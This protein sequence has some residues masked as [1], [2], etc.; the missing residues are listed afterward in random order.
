MRAT[1]PGESSPK[2]TVAL[3]KV[4]LRLLGVSELAHAIGDLAGL[5]RTSI[6][7]LVQDAQK[8]IADHSSAEFTAIGS[9]DR[10]WVEDLLSRTYTRLATDPARHVMGESLIGATAVARLADEAMT[11]EEQREVGAASDDVRAYLTALSESIAYLVSQWYSASQESSR[12]AMSQAAGETLHI[13]REIPGLVEGVKAHLESS[14]ATALARLEQPTQDESGSSPDPESE[15]VR[16]ELDLHYAPI[17]TDAIFTDLVST[18]TVAMLENRPFRIDVSMPT[19]DDEL[20]GIDDAV[21][22]AQL[23]RNCLA[24][25]HGL[26]LAVSAFFS[27]Q[28]EKFWASYLHGVPD[29]VA[30]VRAIFTG[31]KGTR[32]KLDVWRTTPP[33]ASAPIWLTQDEVPAVLESVEL[34]HWDYL[35]GGAGWRAADEL[36]RSIIV[37]KVMPSILTELV[38]REVTAEEGWPAEV[39]FLP[40]WHIGQG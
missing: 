9:A 34:G 17:A 37:E 35:R 20:K 31:Q 22:V 25:A 39:L 38:R 11:A 4:A 14:L 12:A 29:R 2:T 6:P 28:V 5:R 26:A 15:Q 36:P 23:K 27:P 30:V 7:S 33:L 3:T 8:Q 24:K 21:R 32:A 13:V 19:L 10:A 18:A 40:S 1:L 16:F